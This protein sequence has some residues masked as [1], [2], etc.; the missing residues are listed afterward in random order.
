MTDE[1]PT[2]EEEP[3]TEIEI[4]SEAAEMN[5]GEASHSEDD[6][7]KM[8]EDATWPAL[9]CPHYHQRKNDNDFVK[10][11]LIESQAFFCQSLRNKPTSWARG[12]TS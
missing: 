3:M 6:L 5:H 11:V 4:D 10:T 7:R 8:P 12:S 2:M 1:D 9:S